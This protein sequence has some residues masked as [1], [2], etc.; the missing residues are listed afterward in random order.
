MYNYELCAAYATIANGGTY[1]TPTLYTKIVDH[2]GNVLLENPGE[3]HQ[4]IKEGTASLLTSAM[5]TVVTSGTG[6]SCPV[7]YTHLDVYKR[8]R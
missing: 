2:D 8:Q 5:E 1:N 3:S 4:A 6:R 7:S